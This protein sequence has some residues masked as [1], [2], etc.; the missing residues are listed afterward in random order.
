MRMMVASDQQ[1]SECE[2]CSIDEQTPQK[3]AGELRALVE[4]FLPPN[5]AR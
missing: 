1:I 3:P 4:N 5:G 2:D